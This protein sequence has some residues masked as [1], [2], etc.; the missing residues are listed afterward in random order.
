MGDTRLHILI[1]HRI[2]S[3]INNYLVVT[4]HFAYAKPQ[5]MTSVMDNTMTAL[6]M[7]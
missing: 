2:T 1:L 7:Q 6:G 4:E 3:G 5:L